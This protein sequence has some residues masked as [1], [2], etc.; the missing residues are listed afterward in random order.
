M[1]L[2]QTFPTGTFTPAVDS[3][4]ERLRAHHAET[5]HHSLR[6]A[7]WALRFAEEHGPC[8][9]ESRRILS[10]GALLHDL[11]KLLLPVEI[12]SKPGP[13]DA[14]EWEQM[15]EHPRLG[16]EI[17]AGTLDEPVRHILVAHHEFKDSPYPRTRKAAP[18]DTA[19]SNLVAIV[20]AADM[21]DGLRYRRSYKSALRD[22]QV[23][24]LMQIHF[25][26]DPILPERMIAV[27]SRAES[28]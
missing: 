10:Q 7:R 25:S 5:F 26:G 9:G 20:A 8:E 27:A 24:E 12:L 21:Y 15:R 14:S 2:K 1:N 22:P 4:L 23:L 13:L 16:F 3:W 18:L 28:A 11:G 6:V 17:A 19:L